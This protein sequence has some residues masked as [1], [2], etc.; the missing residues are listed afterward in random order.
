M[1]LE[2]IQFQIANR[3]IISLSYIDFQMKLKSV[4]IVPKLLHCGQHYYF[5]SETLS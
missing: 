4:A 5:S 1:S 2:G 3:H